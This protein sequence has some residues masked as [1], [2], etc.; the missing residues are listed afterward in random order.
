MRHPNS[1]LIVEDAE[2]IIRDRKND[3]PLPNQAVSNLLNLS[4]GLLG[5]AMQLHIICTFNCDVT[6]IDPALLREGRLVVEHK[7]DKLNVS[8]ARRLCTVL[9]VPGDGHDIQ[10]PISIS[11]I[12]ARRTADHGSDKTRRVSRRSLA[13]TSNHLNFYS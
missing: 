1:I 7:F 2:N 3:T 9:G 12:Y 11:D 8:N 5:D 13:K 10:E 6:G 4:D